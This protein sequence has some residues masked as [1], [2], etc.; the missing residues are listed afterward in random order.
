MQCRGLSRALQSILGTVGISVL[1]PRNSRVCACA[2]E[3]QFGL[4][5]C[6]PQTRQNPGRAE[7]MSTACSPQKRL[8]EKMQLNRA[9]QKRGVVKMIESAQNSF[10][11]EPPRLPSTA[12]A[13]LGI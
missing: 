2:E 11:L 12:P 8:A 10:F 13:A 1:S 7:D 6:G 4:W 9:K 5:F 3:K